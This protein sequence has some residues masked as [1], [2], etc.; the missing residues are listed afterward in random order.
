MTS[1]SKPC[2]QSGVIRSSKEMSSDSKSGTRILR[3]LKPDLASAPRKILLI[4]G[5]EGGFSDQ[6]IE[7]ARA[8]GC[9]IAGLGPRILKAETATLAACTLVQYIYGDMG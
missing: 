3:S 7:R 1:E 2:D 9:I 8:A 5:P 6:E 4:L